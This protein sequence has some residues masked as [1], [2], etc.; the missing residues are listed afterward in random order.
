MSALLESDGV[1]LEIL[2]LLANKVRFGRL[3]QHNSGRCFI[4]IAPFNGKN[5]VSALRHGRAR[6]DTDGLT[7]L[8]LNVL[9]GSR[10]CLEA[11]DLQ[12][13]RITC[14]GIKTTSK[15]IH[16]RIIKRRIVD[17]AWQIHRKHAP[18]TFVKVNLLNHQ[19]WRG[20]LANFT[21][22]IHGNKIRYFSHLAHLLLDIGDHGP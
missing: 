22:L 15:P 19:V 14:L 3:L 1:F 12:R 13:Q 8:H 7:V 4:N 10:G 11:D 16:G 9:V 5:S 21:G 20:L 2:T 17:Q 6:H 18:V